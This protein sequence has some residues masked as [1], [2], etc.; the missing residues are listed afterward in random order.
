MKRPLLRLKARRRLRKSSVIITQQ[1]QHASIVPSLIV[2]LAKLTTKI[3]VKP[4]SFQFTLKAQR[5]Q[6]VVKL[7]EVVH[8]SFLKSTFIA[9]NV[10]MDLKS[11]LRYNQKWAAMIPQ[12]I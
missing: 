2:K 3:R 1:T 12:L 6:Q 10:R 5:R 4:V 9:L 8:L 11:N 7:E